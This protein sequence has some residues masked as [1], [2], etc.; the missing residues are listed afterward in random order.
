[1]KVRGGR[2]GRSDLEV[3]VKVGRVNDKRNQAAHVS[4]ERKKG[5][6]HN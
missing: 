5:Q 1:V 4:T 2:G 3:A 6:Q